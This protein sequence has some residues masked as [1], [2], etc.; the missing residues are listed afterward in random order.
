M[1]RQRR[2]SPRHVQI[3]VVAGFVAF[4]AFPLAL[5]LAGVRPGAPDN[6]APSARP[7]LGARNLVDEA[8]YQ[9]LDRFL[10]DRF[11]F[12]GLAI[13]VNAKLNDKVWKGDTDQVRRGKGDWLYYAPSLTRLCTEKLTPAG[14]VDVLTRFAAGA[15]A[16][17][18]TFRY[19][20]APEKPSIYPEFLSGRSVSDLPCEAEAREQV[21]NGLQANGSSWYLDL[22]DDLAALK[23]SSEEPIY[24]PRDTHWTGIGVQVMF[25]RLL[26]SLQPGLWKPEEYVNTGDEAFEPDLTRL[27][28]L[29]QT[30]QVPRYEVQ[31]P[32]VVTTED[33]PTPVPG[34]FAIRHFTSRAQG[35]TALVKGKTVMIYDSFTIGSIP[36]LAPYFED[37]TF[38]HWNALGKVDAA[39]TLA[40]ATTV[41]AEGAEREF[42]WRMGE[43]LSA[44]GLVDAFG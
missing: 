16:A 41:V 9:K 40:A 25:R 28:G 37:I 13:R 18:K 24:H 19:T 36:N 42:T 35:G 7:P 32:G 20:L 11:A 43:K 26:D 4:L 17:G 15:Q 21:R 14:G 23:A 38:I 31:R 27:L 39:P 8:T 44:T 10:Q 2:L 5:T 34:D 22:Y 33:E 29:T 30:V 1:S 6:R 3:L 12:R